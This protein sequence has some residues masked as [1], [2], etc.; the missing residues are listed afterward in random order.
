MWF[1]R[2]SMLFVLPWLMIDTGLHG[3]EVDIQPLAPPFQVNDNRL[4]LNQDHASVAMLEDGR[5]LIAWHSPVTRDSSQ[6]EIRARLFY[7]DGSPI[8]PELPVAPSALNQDAPVVATDGLNTFFIAWNEGD[9]R[10]GH[11][12]RARVL[13]IDGRFLSAPVTLS[14][15]P[16]AANTSP[17]AGAGSDGIAC[18]VWTRSNGETEDQIAAALNHAGEILWSGITLNLFGGNGVRIQSL[19]AISMQPDGESVVAWAFENPEEGNTVYLRRFRTTTAAPVIETF[20]VPV[21]PLQ[22]NEQVAQRPTVD[23]GPQ[24]VVFSGWNEKGNDQTRLWATRWRSE[25]ATPDPPVELAPPVPATSAERFV[26]TSLT[27]TRLLVLYAVEIPGDRGW[28]ILLQLFDDSLRPV[29]A[30]GDPHRGLTEGLQTRPAVAANREE[31]PNRLVVTWESRHP[32]LRGSDK[33][34]EARIFTVETP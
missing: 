32:E 10:R 28:D 9:D 6:R 12:T 31:G 33:E 3:Q 4:A 25:Q 11:R 20:E 15:A 1:W 21:R 24:G 17:D 13:Q 26:L 14:V 8:T 19:P 34:I 16:S 27:A 30:P 22:S 29:T 5:F 2:S 18:V 7:A 23:L